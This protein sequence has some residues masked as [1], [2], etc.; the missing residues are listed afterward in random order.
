MSARSLGGEAEAIFRRHGVRDPASGVGDRRRHDES[1]DKASLLESEFSAGPCQA[2]N[3]QEV[4]AR[5]SQS[6][7]RIFVILEGGLASYHEPKGGKAQICAIHFPGEIVPFGWPGA[8]MPIALKAVTDAKVRVF[9]EEALE[10]LF[11]RDA[12]RSLALFS[13]ICAATLRQ[14]EALYLQRRRSVEGRLA[15]F[16]LDLGQHL[17]VREGRR[18][19][20][21]LPM[22]R[23]EI[24]SF[25]GASKRDLEPDLRPLA[26]GRPDRVRRTARDHLSRYR[27]PPGHRQGLSI[28]SPSPE[29]WI[30]L[31][32]LKA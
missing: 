13:K 1:R 9:T 5:S 29:A 19:Q 27:P 10:A 28:Q 32:A 14:Q 30:A 25:L 15:N 20:V 8:V 18:L 3:R 23:C 6:G 26:G 21:S 7:R 31:R 17:G 24:A 12:K 4:L 22:R 2:L 16:L 11:Q